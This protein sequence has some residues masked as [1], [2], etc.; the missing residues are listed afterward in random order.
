MAALVTHLAPPPGA[1]GLAEVGLEP[2][3]G[4]VVPGSGVPGVGVPALGEP[5]VGVPGSGEPG[6][7]GPVPGDCELGGAAGGADVALVLEDVVGACGAALWTSGLQPV[8]MTIV[9]DTVIA[10][11]IRFGFTSKLL[12][13]LVIQR[14]APTGRV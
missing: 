13:L 3:A 14:R 6:L 4:L 9:A 2:E 10:G 11:Q 5:G 8:S 12:Y 7:D 1:D